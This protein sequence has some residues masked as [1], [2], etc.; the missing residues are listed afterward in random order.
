MLS[1]VPLM[2]IILFVVT[3]PGYLISHWNSSLGFMVKLFK[4]VFGFTLFP[5]FWS[6]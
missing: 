3:L 2:V 4:L 6:E 1:L 5:H